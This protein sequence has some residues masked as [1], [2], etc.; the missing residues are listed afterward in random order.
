MTVTT[1]EAAAS[2]SA[3]HRDHQQDFSR[4]GPT[5]ASAVPSA[6]ST[7]YLVTLNSGRRPSRGWR[8]CS[9]VRGYRPGSPPRSAPAAVRRRPVRDPRGDRR[10]CARPDH[11]ADGHGDGLDGSASRG[12]W[13]SR[14]PCCRRPDS[15]RWA[16]SPSPTAR[17]SAGVRLT[18]GPARAS[19]DAAGNFQ[20]LDV[21]AGPQMLGI[22]ANAARPGLPIYAVEV[23]LVAGQATQ[24]APLRITPPPPA[25][26]FVPIAN[27]ATATGGHRSAVS[28]AS[29]SRFPR[30]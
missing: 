8:H 26:R 1:L 4:T 18:I 16:G 20:L 11:R 30:V 10:V 2:A 25:E 17:R 15:A 23:M 12:T 13:R 19:T 27:G 29:R 5:R 21:P 14:W 7:T 28:G 24:L 6:A 9:I 22:D 3:V